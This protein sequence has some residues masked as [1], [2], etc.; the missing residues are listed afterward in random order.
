MIGLVALVVFKNILDHA[1]YDYNR[2][3]KGLG[4]H[5]IRNRYDGHHLHGR[6]EQ[7]IDVRHFRKLLNQVL[8]QEVKFRVL[9]CRDH[10]GLDQLRR[11]IDICP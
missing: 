8:R 5:S 3:R 1:Q 7:K 10:V 2:E 6:D 9:G 4:G 11:V